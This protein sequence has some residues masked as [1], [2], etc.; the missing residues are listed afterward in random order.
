MTSGDT[1]IRSW[2]GWYRRIALA[3]WALALLAV[4]RAAHLPVA[5]VPQKRCLRPTHKYNCS[6]KQLHLEPGYESSNRHNWLWD[7]Y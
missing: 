3:M 2:T 4:L 7:S 5:P 1:E 6:T